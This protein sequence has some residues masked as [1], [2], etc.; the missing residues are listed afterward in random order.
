MNVNISNNLGFVS[1]SGSGKTTIINYI[2]ETYN[3]NIAK[4]H[5]T[6]QK[7]YTNDNEY[8]FNTLE[9]FIELE[10]SGFFFEVEYLFGNYYG[11]PKTYINSNECTIFNVDIN[12]INRLKSKI[13][14]TSIMILPPSI[15]ELKQRLI[16]R[17]GVHCEKRINRMF[18]EL[19]FIP[20][21]F[22]IN[23]DLPN[24]FKKTDE[25]INMIFYQ[26]K[27]KSKQLELLKELNSQ[28]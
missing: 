7:R 18:D 28:S 11:T 16:I 27:T 3:L 21:F 4:S 26:W 2:S 5:T 10:K 6:R 8:V 13:N 14:L 17:D 22:I 12:G 15:S 24:V 20:D 9:E 1:P 19:L 25:L 23:D